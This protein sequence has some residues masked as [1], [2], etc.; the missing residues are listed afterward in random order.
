MA[1]SWA[2]V[3]VLA[4]A[5]SSCCSRC[6]AQLQ[7]QEGPPQLPTLSPPSPP[8]WIFFPHPALLPSPPDAPLPDL[9]TL[10]APADNSKSRLKRA[11]DPVPNCLDALTHSCWSSPPGRNSASS[12]IEELE[13]AKDIEIGDFYF[14]EKNYRGA[15][16]RYR[17]AL[18]YRPDEPEATFKL[19]ECLNKLGYNDE[20]N[21]T[22][23]PGIFEDSVQRALLGAS[24]KGAGEPGAEVPQE[25]VNC[26]LVDYEGSPKSVRHQ[27][28]YRG[29]VD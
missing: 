8:P 25:I 15:E 22:K 6:N 21:Q 26:G 16:S 3:V 19:A 14:K 1:I 17:D 4:V 2:R 23:V 12:S 27:P 9:G 24:S 20:A 28:R 11:I 13:I 18:S 7:E 5:V 10:P 29:S